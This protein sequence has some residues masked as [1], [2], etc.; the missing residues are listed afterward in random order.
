[1]SGSIITLEPTEGDDIQFVRWV[2][3]VLNGLIRHQHPQDVYAVKIDHWF[4]HKWQYYSGNAL[5]A[6]AVWKPR[7]TIPPFD[8]GRVISQCH[9][10]VTDLSYELQAAKPLHLDQWSSY[11]LHRYI[12]EVSSAGL[13]LWY[14]GETKKLD[15]ASVMV[16]STDADQASTWYASFVKTNQWRLNKVRGISRKQFAELAEQDF[17]DTAANKSKGSAFRNVDC[18]K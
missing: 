2:A 3:Q 6:L 13:F 16:Y 10:R 12:T 1:M 14:S 15:R 9:F 17:N 5:G 7:V 11:N 4:D 8:P 18:V